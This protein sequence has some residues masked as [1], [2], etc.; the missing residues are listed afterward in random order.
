MRKIQ[1]GDLVY[2]L[3]GKYKG[4]TGEVLRVFPERDMVLVKGINIVKR[5]VRPNPQMPTAPSGII[6]GER[7]IHVSNVMLICP[8]CGKPTRVGFRFLGGEG[9]L[10]RRKIRYCKR[11]GADIPSKAKT[12]ATR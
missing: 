7:P 2:V 3:T 4:L 8:T 6:E 5:H 11:C 10:S 12:K 1:T 9:K